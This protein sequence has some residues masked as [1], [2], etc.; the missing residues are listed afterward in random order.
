[1]NTVTPFVETPIEYYRADNNTIGIINKYFEDFESLAKSEK[2]EEIISQG[3]VALNAAKTISS[4]SDEAKICAQLTSTAFYLGNYTLALEYAKR[5]HELSEVFVSPSLFIR[6]LYLESAIHRAL[7]GKKTDEQSQQ[8]FYK[9]A[10]TT[11]E[12]AIQVYSKKT[13]DDENLKG[14]VYFNL[15]AAHADNPK[16][17]LEEAANCYAIAIKCFKSIKAADDIIRTNIRFGKVCLL[18]KKY[19]LSQEIIQEVRS[20]VSSERLAMHADYLEAQLKYALNDSSNALKIANNGLA[21]A[22]SLGAKEDEFRI[23]SLIESINKLTNPTNA[24]GAGRLF[25]YI[26]TLN[27]SVGKK[28]IVWFLIAVGS[29]ILIGSIAMRIIKSNKK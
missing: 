12:E 11:A 5:C 2:W 10:V 17:N 27:H 4:T 21:R 23:N 20:Q 6:A 7:A 25:Q 19:A 28:S 15:G 3:T 24:T 1:M 26:H 14:K 29:L 18:Q 8:K 9:L 22:K 16:G 13:V